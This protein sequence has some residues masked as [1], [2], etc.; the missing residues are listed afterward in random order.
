MMPLSEPEFDLR[1]YWRA[2][3]GRWWLLP[4]GLV[5]GAIVGFAV[6]HGR[7]QTYKASAQ[8]Y[9]GD[10]ASAADLPTN[11]ALITQYVT[12]ESTLRAAGRRAHVDPGKLR[13]NVSTS[14]VLGPSGGRLG[15]A[16][17]AL[18]DVTVS[19]SNGRETVDAANELARSASSLL[20]RYPRQQ[21]TLT[22]K[23]LAR[24]QALLKDTTARLNS[25]LRSREQLGS[26]PGSTARATVVESRAFSEAIGTE[27]KQQ[28]LLRQEVTAA[29]LQTVFDR[30]LSARVTRTAEAVPQGVPSS[31]SGILVGALI[32]ILLAAF[33]AIATAPVTTKPLKGASA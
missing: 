5:L 1:R 11:L 28:A 27:L 25:N 31:A 29:Q 17:S 18:V 6:L 26:G 14:L 9:T 24:N 21:L 19:G 3:V 20:E 22:L 10:T 16:P 13:G 2:I 33:A 12:S 30:T 23:S 32:G 4:A 8:I 7:V 15:A